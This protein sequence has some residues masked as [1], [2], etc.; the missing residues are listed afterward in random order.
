MTEEGAEGSEAKKVPQVLVVVQVVVEGKVVKAMGE[1]TTAEE[2]QVNV[3]DPTEEGAGAA[4]DDETQEVDKG[5]I[6]PA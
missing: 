5:I 1:R 2:V 3:H 4:V 6:R